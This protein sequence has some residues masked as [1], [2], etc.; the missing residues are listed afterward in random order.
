GGGAAAER[1]VARVKL[2]EAASQA[3]LTEE[4]ARELGRAADQ[5]KAEGR[6]DEY[7][8]VTE[9]LLFH[10]PENVTKVRELAEAYI[11]RGN[12][13][14]ALPKLQAWLKADPRDPRAL[15][16]LARALEQL[17]QV[18]KAV[19][20]LKELARLCHELGRASERDAA[21]VRGVTLA[22]DDPELQAL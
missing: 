7:L 14:L 1:R 17:G 8:R 2:A 19:S 12:P 15:S 10:Q 5:L 6:S 13:R 20:V 22:P 11:T 9:R 4:A 16:L 21:V 18:P 3:G